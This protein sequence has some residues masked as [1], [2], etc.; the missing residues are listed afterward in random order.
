MSVRRVTHKWAGLRT[1]TPDRT[2]V[3]GFDPD[4]EG[5]FW[6][7]GQGGYG[8]QTAPSMAQACECLIAGAS[9]PESLGVPPEALAPRRTSQ[10]LPSP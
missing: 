7:A 5:F 2:P 9:W 3:A 10:G 8:L 6:L 1:F 4:V